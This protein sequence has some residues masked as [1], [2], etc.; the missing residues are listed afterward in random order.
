MGK[1][2]ISEGQDDSDSDQ[3]HLK[4]LDR[5]LTKLKS[6]SINKEFVVE[7]NSLVQ[8]LEI[9]KKELYTNPKEKK[10]AGELPL[11]ATTTFLQ[12]I[13]SLI[14]NADDIVW[15][16]DSNYCLIFGNSK[17]KRIC[18]K[19][20]GAEIEPGDSV[21]MKMHSNAELEE[22]KKYYDRAISGEKFV[23]KEQLRQSFKQ[24]WN[25]NNFRPLVDEKNNFIGALVVSRDI[26]EQV[27]AENA[28]QALVES[29]SRLKSLV[30][31]LQINAASEKELL[32]FT[33]EHAIKLTNSKI[34]YIY[35]YNESTEQFTLYSWSKGVM[36]ECSIV[37]P[38]TVYNLKETGI[39]GEAVRQRGPI[40]VNDFEAEHPLKKGYPQGHARLYK[41]LTLPVIAGNKI[42]AVIGV[43]NKETDYKET[44][45]LHIT[46][47][48]GHVWKAL[49]K[50]KMEKVVLQQNAQLQKLNADKDRFISILAHDLKDPFTSILGMADLLTKNIH[51]YSINKIEEL[52]NY[53]KKSAQN[54]YNLLMDILI[55]ARAQSGNLPFS[56]EFFDLKE[57]I[58]ETISTLKPSAD[59]KNISINV[60]ADTDLVVFADSHMLK[61][62]LRNLISNAIKFTNRGGKIDVFVKNSPD[63]VSISVSDDGVGI[64]P[65][66]KAQLF[67]ITQ[68]VSTKGTENESGT[69]LGLMLCKEFIDKHGGTMKIDSDPGNGTAITFSIKK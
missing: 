33:L 69:G 38:K 40:L 27:A 50:L 13:F 67:D 24:K 8:E 59:T 7:H 41:F 21:I 55:W 43:A 35:F 36:S 60:L 47:L 2:S 56:P 64:S 62:I 28:H 26:T 63:D 11:N 39:W 25:E 14:E 3:L 37:D 5:L 22:W 30:E 29:E 65:E 51:K 23:I 66:I 6:E 15:A 17:Y 57:L 1:R 44:D 68:K 16:V 45:I 18:L 54:T 19:K 52:V 4:R 53:Q 20:I 10:L 61:T 46:I 34:G 58:D 42:V 48:M 32:D 12:N 49:E 9:L 31:I